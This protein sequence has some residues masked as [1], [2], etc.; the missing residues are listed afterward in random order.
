MTKA[1]DNVFPKLIGSEAAAPGTPAAATAIL[2][3]KADGLWYSK[4][5][6]GVETL[7]SG[8]TGGGNYTGVLWSSGISM[9]G[10]PATNQRV[11]RTDLGLDFFYNGT[12]WLTT[13]LYRADAPQGKG[14]SVNPFSA[15]F[16]EFGYLTP[17]HTTF[18]LWLEDFWT[19]TYVATTNSGTS[20]W[21]VELYKLDSAF[22]ATTVINFNTS[23]DTVNTLTTHKTAIGALL[24][25]AT[26]RMLTTKGTKTVTPGNITLVWG[27]S[28]RLVGV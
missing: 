13:T 8:G 10:A 18:D 26:Y 16:T 25:P 14:T 9:P 4:D 1:S 3:V 7:V 27:V 5:D 22:A 15:N 12:R 28:Y 11:T 23:A 2:Y 20:Y 24:T 21:T 17:W 19:S 6:A